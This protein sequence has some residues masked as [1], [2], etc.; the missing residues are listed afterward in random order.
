VR[1]KLLVVLAIIGL[2]VLLI[3]M[4]IPVSA[5]NAVNSEIAR[6]KPVIHNGDTVTYWVKIYNG[7][8]GEAAIL[9]SVVFWPADANGAYS[10]ALEFPLS[11]IGIADLEPGDE[12]LFDTDDITPDDDLSIVGAHP[13]KRHKYVG[14][15]AY[16]MNLNPNILTA[17]ARTVYTGYLNNTNDPKDD[18]SGFKDISVSIIH[19][20]TVVTIEAKPDEVKTGGVTDI[21]ITETNSATWNIS[22]PHVV[23]T[24][25]RNVNTYDLTSANPYINPATYLVDFGGDPGSDN[26][27][28]PGETWNW[29]VHDVPVTSP[30]TIFTATGHGLDP[31]GLDITPANSGA[32]GNF[33]GEQA[34]D[35][36]D[37][38]SPNTDVGISALPDTV[39]ADGGMVTLTVTEYNDGHVDLYNVQVD[40]NDGSGTIATLTQPA[41][42]EDNI[43]QAGETWTWTIN[44]FVANTTT[45]TAIGDGTYESPP[46]TVHHVTYSQ[47]YPYEREPVT[48]NRLPGT[49]ASSNLTLWLLI[50]GLAGV[51]VYVG[52]R[53]TRK[54][55]Q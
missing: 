28:L 29:T 36:V 24:N 14:E 1:K 53:R 5:S 31:L 12:V 11:A 19:P 7:S 44:V 23:L 25:N 32:A 48:V 21:T 52:Y 26:K 30:Y 51:M 37:V 18:A 10:S 55:H 8:S 17:Q 2:L 20:N 45:F 54:S 50:A 15:L 47:E 49:P 34:S 33:S 35:R 41:G 3:P 42:E 39:P 6:D 4:A 27:L 13:V 43:L 16:T 38:L 40:V 22:A 46:G 9:T